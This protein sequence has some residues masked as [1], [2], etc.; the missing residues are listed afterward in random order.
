MNNQNNQNNQKQPKQA[1]R[2]NGTYR[3]SEQT[4][5]VINAIVMVEKAWCEVSDAVNEVYTTPGTVNE[6]TDKFTDP[7]TEIERHLGKILIDS[8]TA[9]LCETKNEYQV[10]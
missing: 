9:A 3:V 2:E 6:I 8:V 1:K 7:F 5:K 4:E 10:I